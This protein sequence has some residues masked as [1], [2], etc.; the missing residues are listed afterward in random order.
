MNTLVATHQP[1]VPTNEKSS[2]RQRLDRL[3]R[4]EG[5]P[6]AGW[7][8]EEAEH[9]GDDTEQLGQALGLT[10][11]GVM[12][13]LSGHRDTSRLGQEQ[14]DAASRYLGVPTAVVKIL[15]GSIRM[16]DFLFRH[17]SPAQVVDK[18]ID[19][20]ASDPQLSERLPHDV[21]SLPFAAKQVIALLYAE[22]TSGDLQHIRKLPESVYWLQRA[23]LHVD[24]A[25][26][27]VVMGK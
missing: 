27:R 16:S 22:V 23:A 15:A 4:C 20:L 13:L 1:T 17:Q 5:G 2:A 9:R 21:K 12:H 10:R 14:L 7:L 25:Q 24:E 3:Y 19:E 8:A 11:I 26:G 6:L 18:V